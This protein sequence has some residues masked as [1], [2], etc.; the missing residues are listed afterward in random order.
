M[1]LSIQLV[2][3]SLGRVLRSMVSE[4][5]NP[6]ALCTRVLTTSTQGSVQAGNVASSA[7]PSATS[8]TESSSHSYEADM[9][10]LNADLAPMVPSSSGRNATPVGRLLETHNLSSFAAEKR[11]L[12]GKMVLAK[13]LA[14]K[15]EEILVDALYGV[16]SIPRQDVD[17]THLHG[18]TD[19]RRSTADI[20]PGDMLKL[21]VVEPYTPYGITLL[22]PVQKEESAQQETIWAELQRRWRSR[23]PVQGRVLNPC[24][25]GYAVGVAGMVALLPYAAATEATAKLV[26]ELQP[27]YITSMDTVRRRIEL[28]DPSRASR[29]VL[30]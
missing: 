2:Q 8:A 17:T 22:A 1:P 28:A 27:F 4:S 15:K 20:R 7:E 3:C 21:R 25:G 16:S 23:K 30:F 18:S 24:P 13:V 26:G 11:G 6:Y 5:V 12:K 19:E 14:V 10:E 29:R 9:R